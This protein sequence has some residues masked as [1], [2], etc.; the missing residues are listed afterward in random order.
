MDKVVFE[1]RYTRLQSRIVQE[2]AEAG[3]ITDPVNLY[4]LTG[5]RTNP[6]ERFTG[7]LVPKAGPPALVIPALD[8]EAAGVGWVSD[9]R[10]WKDGESISF[11]GP[12]MGWDWRFMRS[13]T[14]W[15]EIVKGSNREWWGP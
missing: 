7:L 8:V 14:S 11:I 10:G 1:R 15:R 4:Y 3:L 6:H 13:R 9:V 12:A 5:W 2:N